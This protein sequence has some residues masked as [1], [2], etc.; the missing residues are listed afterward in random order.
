MS[1]RYLLRTNARARTMRLTITPDA[2]LIVSAPRFV[3]K[4]KIE[5]FLAKH[6]RWI[7]KKMEYVRN[8]PVGVLVPNRKRD[9]VKYKEAARTLAAERL[10][11]FNQ[12]YGFTYNRITIRNTKSRWGSCSKKGNLNFSYKVALLS[13][14]L[15]DYVILHELCHLGEFNHSRAFWNL[16]SRAMPDYAAR[17]D[18]LKGGIQRH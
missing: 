9:Y 6:A 18:E 14:R 12:H 17:R 11:H 2:R 5:A 15:A 8:M 1:L 4:E 10:A 3:T 7:A 16:M 13:P